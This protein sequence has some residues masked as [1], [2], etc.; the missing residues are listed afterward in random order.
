MS[1]A[2]EGAASDEVREVGVMPAARAAHPAS[3]VQSRA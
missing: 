2:I 3:A 1:R